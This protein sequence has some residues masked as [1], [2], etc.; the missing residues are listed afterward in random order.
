[1]NE[2]TGERV[3]PGRV[4]QD[5]WNEH[6]SRYAFAAR[7][8]AGRKVLDVGCG[9]GYG[10]AE[11]AAN[12]ARVVGVDRAD[13]AV[14]YGREQ[15]SMPNLDFV[16]GASE[17]LPFRDSCFEVV[18]A[19]E[20]IEHLTDWQALIREAARVL[21]PD[22]LFLVSTPNKLYYTES[23][24]TEGANPFHEHE[25]D[26]EEFE[27][28]LAQTFSHVSVLLQNRTECLAFYPHKLFSL[29][30]ARMDSSAGSTAD[31]H[32]F[33]AVCAQRQLDTIRSFAYIPR[34]VNLLRERE[35]HIEKLTREVSLKQQWVD[36]LTTERDT[37]LTNVREIQ[38][39]LEAHNRWALTLERDLES[40]CQRVTVLEGQYAAL[41]AESLAMAQGYEA[42]VAEL[43]QENQARA[44]WAI[45]I[46]ERLTGVIEFERSR[47]GE[48][49]V[50]LEAAEGTAQDRLNW[51]NSLQRR[52]DHIE[53]IMG[54]IRSSRWM[55]LGRQFGL[56]PQI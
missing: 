32:F 48:A 19:F 15:Y 1:V 44:K 27:R 47:L 36:E 54:L 35:Q 5:L 33:I 17:S 31:A 53:Q 21:A 28:A 24:G 13:E 7:F 41:Q 2:F 4:N 3:I 29:V 42:K 49:L 10:T 34:A 38:E 45:E 6:F 51:G 9:T 37:L 56:G 12:A 50:R 43:E 55:R 11:M 22:G 46:E 23:R 14:S 18:S 52:L 30:D 25:F 20:V 26:L 40:A 8:T 39:H 16:R